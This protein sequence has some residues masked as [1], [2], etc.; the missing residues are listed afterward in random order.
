M[1]LLFG[2]YSRRCLRN[3]SHTSKD[4]LKSRTLKFFEER[5]EAPKPFKWSFAFHLQTGQQA[6]TRKEKDAKSPNR[7]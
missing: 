5:N 6:Q 4:H 2:I 3:A 1:K 7:P